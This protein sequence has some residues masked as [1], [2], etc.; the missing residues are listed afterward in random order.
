MEL[1]HVT[2]RIEN[3]T[4]TGEPYELEYPYDFSRVSFMGSE[5]VF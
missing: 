2:A 4:Q 5:T 3:L 1:T